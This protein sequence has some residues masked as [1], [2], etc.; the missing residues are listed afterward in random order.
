MKRNLI[1][2]LLFSIVCMPAGAVLK[3]RDLS[4]T[5]GILRVELEMYYQEQQAKLARYNMMSQ[6]QHQNIIGIMQRSDQTALMLYSQ[7]SDYTF[8]LTYACHEATEQYDEFIKKRLPYEKIK[9]YINTE[10]TRYN[11]LIN[12]LKDIPPSLNPRPAMK[13]D[14]LHAQRPLAMQRKRIPFALNAQGLADRAACLKYATILRDNLIKLRDSISEDNEHYQRVAQKLAR[15][16][17]YAMNRYNQIQHSIFVNGEDNYFTELSR[18]SQRIR[19]AKEDMKDKYSNIHERGIHSEWRGPIVI[20]LSIFVIFYLVVATILSNIILRWFIPKKYRSESFRTRRTYLMMATGVL[21]FALSLM[22]A[23]LSMDHNFVIMASSLLTEFAWL[24]E[25][26]LISLLIRLKPEQL[27]SGFLVYTP[28]LCM[29]FI[30]IVFRII[31][32]PNTLVNLVFPPILLIFTIWQLWITRQHRKAIPR[33]DSFYTWISLLVMMSSCVLSWIGYVLL[34]V[35]IF[36]WWIFQLMAIQT[37]TCCYDLL[38]LYEKTYISRR[39]SNF[40]KENAIKTVLGKK[41]KSRDGTYIHLTWFFDLVS[42]AIVP[43]LGVLSVLLCIYWASDVFDLTATCQNIFMY[44]FIDEKSVIQLSLFKITLV[45]GCWFIFRYI[46]YALRS[47]YHKYRKEI[48][49]ARTGTPNFTLADNLIVLL[50]WGTYIIASLGLLQ[51]PKSGIS[52]VIAGLATGM[53]F[54]MKD[55][56]ENFFY[57]ISLM[58]GRVRVG[59]YIECDGILGKVDS[60]TYQSTQIVTLDGS[61]IAFLNSS[62]FKKN[63]KNLTRNHSYELVK[64]PVGVAYGV[65][66]ED[67]RKILLDA[68]N[69]VEGKDKQG[70]DIVNPKQGVKVLL[71][72]FGDNSVNLVITYWVLVEEKAGFTCKVNE[73][74]YNALNAHHIEIPFPQRDIY[75]KKVET[76]SEIDAEQSKRK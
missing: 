73:A 19:T 12:E 44:N 11:A 40:K 9:S 76:V 2:L 59:D 56:L 30:V 67:V 20:G 72:D 5:L 39:I 25:A 33:S 64:V 35:Q 68:V 1:I 47:F 28:I 16:Y 37:I 74:V 51:V 57:G 36:I 46:N 38:S 49:T 6:S 42:M 50:V 14:S 34:S 61:V 13:G 29:A 58:T 15:I 26:I 32:I 52:V 62:L 22:I 17:Y 63:F 66:V 18:F 75:I 55:L 43:V 10:I 24:L 7:K 65:N 54:A 21:I 8:D 60:I 4:K 41:K 27:R 53:G 23:Q 48:V 71:S 69:E 3:E 31:F 45:S 70:R